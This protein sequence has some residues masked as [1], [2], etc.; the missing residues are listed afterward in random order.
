MLELKEGKEKLVNVGDGDGDGVICEKGDE[1]VSRYD[2][3]GGANVVGMND[4]A[5]AL[6]V[7]GEVKPNAPDNGWLML[8]LAYACLGLGVAG[9]GSESTDCSESVKST[10]SDE[11]G[12]R[13]SSV[14]M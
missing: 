9:S 3:Y 11:A 12:D 8:T 14:D 10:N 2:L 6:S 1:G 4:E 13:S 7:G 5:E